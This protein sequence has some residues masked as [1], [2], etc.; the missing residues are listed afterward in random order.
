MPLWPIIMASPRSCTL[1]DGRAAHDP[2]ALVVMS[3][4]RRR[5]GRDQADHCERGETISDRRV[6]EYHAPQVGIRA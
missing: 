1:G 5:S 2:D 6:Y 3:L 4:L